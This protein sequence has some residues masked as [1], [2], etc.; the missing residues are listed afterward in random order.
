M[1]QQVATS[2]TDAAYEEFSTNRLSR[3]PLLRFMLE[4]LE[5]QGCTV[6][7]RPS[8][9][10]APFRITFET[11]EGERLGIVAYA[12]TANKRETRNRPTDEHRFQIKYGIKDSREHLIWQ[13]P[14]GLYTTLFLGIDPDR[15]IF[16]GAD[17]IL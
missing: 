9:N 6:I 14:Y 11:P 1:R 10:R 13:D 4:A 3:E 12:F 5:E 2:I 15:D 8:P 17:P 7:H 16:I